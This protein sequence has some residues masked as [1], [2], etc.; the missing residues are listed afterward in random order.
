MKV[1]SMERNESISDIEQYSGYRIDSA[2]SIIGYGIGG[3]G[4]LLFSPYILMGL[5]SLPFPLGR[6]NAVIAG[7]YIALL[8]LMV[9]FIGLSVLGLH[10]RYTT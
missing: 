1:N 4:L 6:G 9:L 10:E 5:L 8:V 2:E 3:I 7:F